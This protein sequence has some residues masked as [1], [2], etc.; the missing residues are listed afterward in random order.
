MDTSYLLQQHG[1]GDGLWWGD[2]GGLKRT[3][4]EHGGRQAHLHSVLEAQH[5]WPF[6]LELLSIAALPNAPSV[7]LTNRRSRVHA[8]RKYS[9]S[10]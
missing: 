7:S 5:C 8:C 2:L 10:V 6:R 1:S 9:F 3:K 4:T